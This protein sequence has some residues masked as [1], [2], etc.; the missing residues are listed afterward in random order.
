MLILVLKSL[1]LQWWCHFHPSDTLAIFH[2]LV[3]LTILCPFYLCKDCDM[4]QRTYMLPFSLYFYI[5]RFWL[6]CHNLLLH[7]RYSPYSITTLDCPQFWDHFIDV[8]TIQ[9]VWLIVWNR[10]WL[11]FIIT[12]WRTKCDSSFFCHAWDTPKTRPTQQEVLLINKRVFILMN[13]CFY[14]RDA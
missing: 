4:N 1:F 7:E 3:F 9:L 5:H 13:Q 14:F 12:T 10:H 8:I 11:H 2:R 6:P